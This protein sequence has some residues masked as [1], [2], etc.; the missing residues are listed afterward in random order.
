MVEDSRVLVVHADERLGQFVETSV[1][2]ALG[3]EESDV[4]VEEVDPN[5]VPE[6]VLHHG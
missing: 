3:G 1:E 2:T 5:V 4:S 6:E